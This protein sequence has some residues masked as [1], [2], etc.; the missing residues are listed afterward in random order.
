MDKKIPKEITLE[1]I[2]NII[3]D[4]ANFKKWGPFNKVSIMEVDGFSPDMNNKEYLRELSDR[5]NDRVNFISKKT[6][7]N[8]GFDKLPSEALE[9]MLEL[10]G[11]L[12]NLTGTNA[13]DINA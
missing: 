10:M 12:V 6:T 4:K 7:D 2:E 3:E 9:S 1:V 13:L 8:E 5:I 11:E